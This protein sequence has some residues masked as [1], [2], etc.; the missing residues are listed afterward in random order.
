[1]EKSFRNHIKSTFPYL[2]N[3]KLVIAVSGGVDSMVLLHLCKKIKLNVLVAHC[4]FNL[5]NKESDTDEEFVIKT[6]KKLGLPVH[7]QHFNTTFFAEQHKLSIQMAARELRYRWFEELRISEDADFILT[8]H[9]ANDSLETF[10]IN[11]VRSTGPEGL[12]GIKAENDKI[13]RP[14]LKFSRQK[15]QQYA[16][17]NEIVWR[18][19]SS[20]AST[21]YLRNKIRHQFIPLLEEM[22]PQ[23]LAG[24]ENTQTYLREQ[25]DL[26][27][28]YTEIIFRKVVTRNEY[29]YELDVA[30]LKRLPH[31]KAV[32]YQLLKNFGFTEWNDVLNL[33]EAQS[34]KMVFS[35]THRLIKDR[36]YLLLTEITSPDANKT[37]Q[38]SEKESHV[39]FSGG[40]LHFEY[41]SEIRET[42]KH[43]IYV[44]PEK[45]NYPLQLRHWRKGDYFY[46]FGMQN[47]KKLSDFFKDEKMSLPEKEHVWLLCDK[48]AIIWVVNKRADNRF[49]ISEHQKNILK[50]SFVN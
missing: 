1:M 48:K 2:V 10:L 46:P 30:L 33:L 3:S 50:I 11:L 14:F 37:Y 4:N 19:D 47:R 16:I 45:I 13:I 34:G 18:E 26:V 21:K 6:A 8:A 41:V 38:I 43:C 25:L 29:G 42:N 40:A 20:N 23:F 15:I 39:M 5:R 35:A 28:D 24:F 12:A 22:N 44:N 31:T 9:H 32:L 49:A 36:D 27:E 17:D 7:I